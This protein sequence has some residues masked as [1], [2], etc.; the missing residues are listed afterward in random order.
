[1]AWHLL[2]Q[3]QPEVDS[4]FGWLLFGPLGL[5]HAKKEKAINKRKHVFII[6]LRYSQLTQLGISWKK[7]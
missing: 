4:E 1:L 3:P 6:N 2:Q 5:L 7:F